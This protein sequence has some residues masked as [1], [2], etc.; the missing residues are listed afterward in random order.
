MVL[1]KCIRS[2]SCKRSSACATSCGPVKQRPS[3]PITADENSHCRPCPICQ[4]APGGDSLIGR[5]DVT[6]NG[7]LAVD[8]YNLT[9][10][11]CKALIYLDPLPP[12]EDLDVIYR[13]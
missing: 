3:F 8:C 2:C 9:Y 1:S 12:G 11:S 10:C 4:T 7:K 6:F 13:K 5:L